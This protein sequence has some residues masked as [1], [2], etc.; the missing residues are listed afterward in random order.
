[1]TTHWLDVMPAIP[2]ARLVPALHNGRRVV[3]AED[4]DGCTYVLCEDAVEEPDRYEVLPVLD[5][6]VDLDEPQ[7]M[8]YALRLAQRY[9]VLGTDGAESYRRVV[10]LGPL[11]RRWLTDETTDAD[12]LALARACAE[13]AS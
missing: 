12:R 2:L 6:R 10:A 7:G 5:L 3:L 1:M 9:Y 11:L 4:P 13:V 8:A